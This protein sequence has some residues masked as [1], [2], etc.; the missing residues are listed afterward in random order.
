MLASYTQV[1]KLQGKPLSRAGSDSRNSEVRR[2]RELLADEMKRPVLE[3]IRCAI[4]DFFSN[5]LQ[6]LYSCTRTNTIHSPMCLNYGHVIR[7]EGWG[8]G[9]PRCEECG[10]TIKDPRELRRSDLNS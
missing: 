2:V 3:I 8:R 4:A 5:T 10:V 1:T 9:L 6:F 7:R